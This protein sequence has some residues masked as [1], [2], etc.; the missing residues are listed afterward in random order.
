MTGFWPEVRVLEI[1]PTELGE[2]GDP[3]EMFRNL[4]APSD[5]T[6]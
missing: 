3:G 2:F 1:G 5:L 4:N 6:K